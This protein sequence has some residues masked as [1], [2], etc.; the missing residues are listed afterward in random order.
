MLMLFQITKNWPTFDEMHLHTNVNNR[1]NLSLSVCVSMCSA[2]CAHQ[3]M[4]RTF[5]KI[6]AMKINYFVAWTEGPCTRIGFECA[7]RS[8]RLSLIDFAL[9]VQF[10]FGN[11]NTN[12]ITCVFGSFFVFNWKLRP[13][14]NSIAVTKY[15][16][17]ILF[18]F[19]F[20]FFLLLIVTFER[21]FS[22]QLM[23]R[24]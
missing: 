8:L 14:S 20:L 5:W 19:M 16:K 6:Y 11:G 15:S 7:P 18:R 2:H 24:A 21:L 1:T 12:T 3:S 17:L 4:D 9:F 22:L 13:T 10:T 23:F